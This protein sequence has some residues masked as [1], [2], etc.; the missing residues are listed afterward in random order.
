M[1]HVLDDAAFFRFLTQIDAQLAAEARQRRCPECA[2]PLHVADFPRKPRGCPDSVRE[3]YSS[4]FGVSIRVSN[5][6]GGFKAL[7]TRWLDHLGVH[8]PPFRFA[9]RRGAGNE[10][11]S[12]QRAAPALKRPLRLPIAPV[13]RARRRRPAP[14]ET[15]A[16][17]ADPARLAYQN[18]PGRRG[19]HPR[20][21]YSPASSTYSPPAAMP[22]S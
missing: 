12:P 14:G 8:H 4:R 19:R 16:R 11:R 10:P 18:T 5:R 22:A 17:R 9:L 7:R 1:C 20:G 15:S 3:E 21:S 6:W 13:H 2:G